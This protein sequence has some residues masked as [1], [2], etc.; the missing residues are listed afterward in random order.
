VRKLLI[1]T[2]VEFA[3]LFCSAIAAYQSW[4]CPDD[5]ETGP[6]ILVF[7]GPGLIVG[8]MYGWLKGRPDEEPARSRHL[9]KFLLV[10]CVAAILSAIAFIVVVRS[11]EIRWPSDR[12]GTRLFSRSNSDLRA[13][14]SMT[15]LAQPEGGHLF[16]VSREQNIAD[17]DRVVPRLAGDCLDAGHFGELLRFRPDERQLALFGKHQK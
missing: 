15:S 11:I 3:G 1:T 13:E 14:P 4:K 10:A 8:G 5:T 7:L 16:A 12:P 9:R 6:G 2:F 17:E